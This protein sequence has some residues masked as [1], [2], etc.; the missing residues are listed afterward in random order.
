MSVAVGAIIS[1]SVGS[2]VMIVTAQALDEGIILGVFL[3]GLVGGQLTYKPFRR[4]AFAGALVA[5]LSL[6]AYLQIIPFLDESGFITV[7]PIPPDISDQE[8]W[9]AFF[10]LVAVLLV[11]GAGGGLLGGYLKGLLRPPRATVPGTCSNC[12]S[13]VPREALFCPYCGE[14]VQRGDTASSEW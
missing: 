8:I 12:N 4:A 5:F 11:L 13:P 9:T 2:A 10:T 1:V 7:P 14:R 6:M 3:G